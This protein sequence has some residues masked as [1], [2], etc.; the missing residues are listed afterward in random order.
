MEK[1]RMDTLEGLKAFLQGKRA[2]E[3][4]IWKR[5]DARQRLGDA[6]KDALDAG[7]K[8]KEVPTVTEDHRRLA[9]HAGERA[10]HRVIRALRRI[11][12]GLRV[13]EA[14]IYFQ[15]PGDTF[16][17]NYDMQDKAEEALPYGHGDSES[18]QGFFYVPAAKAQEA[19]EWFRANGAEAGV[20]VTRESDKNCYP[21][22]VYL[23]LD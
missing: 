21:S 11:G 17:S 16:D 1:Y 4:R 18:G 3:H 8:L 12:E 20:R 10:K 19:L 7:L 2:Q 15:A 22:L 14:T 6:V 13:C 9:M 23:N 5:S